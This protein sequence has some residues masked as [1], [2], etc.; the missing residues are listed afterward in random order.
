GEDYPLRGVPTRA[1]EIDLPDF[2]GLTLRSTMFQGSAAMVFGEFSVDTREYRGETFTID[3][4]DGTSDEISFDLFVTSNG[5]KDEPTLHQAIRLN[6]EPQDD[7][8]L[9]VTIVKE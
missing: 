9:V 1:D 4:G 3:W 8:M 5:R 2:N 7:Q 6:G